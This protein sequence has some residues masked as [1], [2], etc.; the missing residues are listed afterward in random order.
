MAERNYSQFKN[1][2]LDSLKGIFNGHNIILLKKFNI[3]TLDQFF[4]LCLDEQLVKDI[5]FCEETYNTIMGINRLLRCKYLNED[6]EIDFNFRNDNLDDAKKLYEK[7]GFS[8]NVI[9]ALLRAGYTTRIFFKTIGMPKSVNEFAKVKN[10]G[11]KGYREIIAKISIVKNYYNNCDKKLISKSNL[12]KIK[13]IMLSQLYGMFN[14][15][16]LHLLKENGIITLEDLFLKTKDVSNV[17]KMCLSYTIDPEHMYH[18]IMNT[19]RLLRCR[20]FNEDPLINVLFR[21]NDHNDIKTLALQLGYSRQVYVSLITSNFTPLKLY[22]MIISKESVKKLLDTGIFG[23]SSANEIV[24]KAR[25]VI[26]FYKEHPNKIKELENLLFESELLIKENLKLQEH[27]NIIDDD[28]VRL[29]K[30]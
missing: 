4:V 18:I 26:D 9:Y 1:I 30:L 25:I 6:P 16:T 7:L 3:V 14:G 11:I 27:I 5:C 21:S 15:Y 29:R 23:V 2:K 19:T 28:V 24:E 8:L 12:V 22:K 20:F 17:K 10:L 13:D